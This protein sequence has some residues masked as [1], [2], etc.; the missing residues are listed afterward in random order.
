[1]SAEVDSVLS[2]KAVVLRRGD[3]PCKR[4][5]TVRIV[6]T[7]RSPE[8]SPDR[9]GRSSGGGSSGCVRRLVCQHDGRVWIESD[10]DGSDN[11]SA[12][13]SGRRRKRTHRRREESLARSY[14]KSIRWIR[15]RFGASRRNRPVKL[16]GA[17]G[18]SFGAGTGACGA[19]VLKSSVGVPSKKSRSV[20]SATTAADRLE[21]SSACSWALL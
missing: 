15:R 20:M 2:E 6:R 7:V 18:Q 21:P 8:F 12:A 16:F 1:M 11:P 13:S 14:S 19:S 3:F 10:P 4:V 5:E 17:F 9:D